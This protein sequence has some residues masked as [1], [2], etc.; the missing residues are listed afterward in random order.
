LRIFCIKVKVLD[1]VGFYRMW[2]LIVR[3]G[4]SQQYVCLTWTN[5]CK[6]LNCMATNME[7]SAWYVF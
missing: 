3:L 5:D 6:L 7:L 4:I 2:L 1:H